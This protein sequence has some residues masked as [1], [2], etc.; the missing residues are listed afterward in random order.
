MLDAMEIAGRIDLLEKVKVVK[1]D[2]EGS[3]FNCL[4][5]GLNNEYLVP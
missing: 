4:I 5:F 3:L 2:A 1:A